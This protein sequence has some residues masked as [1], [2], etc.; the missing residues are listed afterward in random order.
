MKTFKHIFEED[1]LVI[2]DG[3][4]LDADPIKYNATFSLTTASL[5][6]FEEA[7]GQ[8]LITAMTQLMP[9]NIITDK[10]KMDFSKD[11]ILGLLNAKFIRALASA[12]YLKIEN[13]KIYNNNAT[14]TEFKESPMNELCLIDI[15]F[16]QKI[17]GLA[18]RCLSDER[19]KQNKKAVVSKK[20]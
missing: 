7:Y 1:Q 4:I 8:P 5:L 20:K 14:Q 17:M 10:E 11:D 3:E 12:C 9:S 6:M 2:I 18:T 16:I 15:E 13:G 19:N